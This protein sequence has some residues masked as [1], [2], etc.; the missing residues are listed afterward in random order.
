M[1]TG[2]VDTELG[3]QGRQPGDAIERLEDDVR[4]T[5]AV[6]RDLQLVAHVPV[7]LE[8]QALVKCRVRSCNTTWRPVG[9]P[10]LQRKT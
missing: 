4:R 8:R 1:E 10:M 7:G 5:V 3:H 2:E 9:T 6:V